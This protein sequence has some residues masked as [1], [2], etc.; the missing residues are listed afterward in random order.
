MPSAFL[1][2]WV[3]VVQ[4]LAL[5]A[6]HLYGADHD[7]AK[8]EP[9]IQKFEQIGQT[10]PPPKHGVLFIGSSTIRLWTNLVADFPS[11]SVIN[12]G[13][14]GSEILDSTHFADRILFPYEPRAIVLRAGGNDLANGKSPEQVFE[15][16]K[17]F[18]STVRA[19]LPRADLF[20][21]SWSPTPGRVG[22]RDKETALNRMIE[23]FAA[24]A[25]RLRYIETSDVPLGPDG[26]PRPELFADKLHFNAAGYK[27]LAARVRPFLIPTDEGQW[28]PVGLSGGGGMFSPA[29]STADPDLMFI[30]C[31]MSGAYISE[32]GGHNW[33]MIN[34][35]QLRSDTGCR[36]AFHPSDPDILYASSGGQLRV[37]YDRGLTFKPIGDL[38]ESLRGE[39]A[40]NA[41]DPQLMLAGSSGGKCWV[42]QNAGTNWIVCSGPAG[43]LLGLHFDQTRQGRTVFA[44]TDKGVW[45]SE[46]GG[47]TWT[48]KARGLPWKELQ[49]FAG[50]SSSNQV[51]LY[52]TIRSKEENGSFRGG[53]YRSVDRGETWEPAMGQG[54][55]TETKPADAYSHDPI[56]QYHQL[57]TSD[58]NPSTV[59]VFNTAT[60]FH[61]PHF[62]TV[63]RS[64]DAGRNWRPTYYMDPRFKEYNVAPDYG[65]ASTGQSYKG[66]EVPF[67]V[68]ACSS[69]PDRVLLVRNEPHITH[70]GG[71]GWFCGS[72]YPAPGSKPGP[73]SAW[74]CNGL[75]VTTT[76][77]Y[78]I[79]PFE[80]NRHYI[81]YT[82]LGW[83]RSMDSGKTW[84][85]WDP[86]TWAP[87]R[88]TCY[89]LA[90]DPEMPGLIWGAFSNVH[91]IPND[92]IISERHG[93][94]YPGGV[95]VSKDFGASWKPATNGLPG[96]AVTTVVID[97]KSPRSGRT[98]YTGVFEGGV[99]KSVDG[100]QSWTVKTNGLGHPKNMRVYRVSLHSDGTLFAIICAKR[101]GPRQP[102]MEEGAGLYRSKD[103]AET[104]DKINGSQ[105]FLY[106]KDFSVDSKDSRR[107]LVGCCDVNW[108]NKV[109]GLYLTEDGGGSWR[110]IGREGSQTF[111]GYFHPVH[112]GW[113]YMTLTEGAPGAGL[114]LSKDHGKSW[115]PFNHLP[116]SNIQ[117]VEFDPAD[118]EHIYLATFGGSVWH[119]PAEPESGR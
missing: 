111:G 23:D 105:P 37:S 92:N 39:I 9:E 7:F 118:S 2:R 102:L 94:K 95:C 20:Y 110:R 35:A 119:G 38:K 63:Y 112:P 107:V 99:Y 1:R 19:K 15:D 28:Q 76:W 72:T 70:N 103:G 47:A 74:A 114:W 45:R 106:P 87:W 14:G 117:R 88:N 89:E 85:W 24:Q 68:A 116:F 93:N 44:G 96:R 42:S 101:S 5:G 43:K 65:T 46:D 13:F 26:Q 58:A 17:D 30:N 49:G 66:G 90:F 34:Q 51:I 78:Y 53:I 59:Y 62:D 67:G 11:L 18:V 84:I 4:G 60:G 83:A 61:P 71:R 86:K 21:I 12:R 109:G 91:D 52:C 6:F 82:D 10:N 57:L 54:L 56:C 33:R 64:D 79:D 22:Q 104:W 73:G 31:D 69:D 41:A 36:P 81:C 75:V 115:A 80:N 55:N 27:L 97:P 16:F 29:I 50:G 98:L 108:E 100:G 113:I 48:E 8:W 32:D 40:I 25:P 77:H 3:L